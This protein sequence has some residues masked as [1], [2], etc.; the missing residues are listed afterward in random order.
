MGKRGWRV[1]DLEL[2]KIFT[3]HDVTFYE[4]KFPFASP[5][6]NTLEPSATE[7]P[8]SG[9]G[10]SLNPCVE[11]S[12]PNL[13][14]CGPSPL[15]DSIGSDC[16]EAT[17]PKIELDEHQPTEAQHAGEP[18]QCARPSLVGTSPPTEHSVIRNSEGHAS[19]SGG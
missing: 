18:H 7:K 8:S 3:S 6:C 11:E 14:E 1:Y 15:R 10:P 13:L 4:D 9:V 2:L 12:I 5:P 19:P 17:L 16:V